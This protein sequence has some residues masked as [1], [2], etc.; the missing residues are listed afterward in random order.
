MYG[1]A[2]HGE[3]FFALI[4][5]IAGIFLCGP[6]TIVGTAMA[7]NSLKKGNTSVVNYIAMAVGIIGFLL[8]VIAIII[9]MR[10]PQGTLAEYL[11]GLSPR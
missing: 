11:R 2:N 9:V 6:L 10:D 3:A 5:S 7:F 8:R 4:V 1:N